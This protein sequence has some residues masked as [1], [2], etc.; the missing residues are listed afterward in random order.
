M[1][2]P[3]IRFEQYAKLGCGKIPSSDAEK[4]AVQIYTSAENNESYKINKWV[5]YESNDRTLRYKGKVY[6]ISY[7]VSVL[8]SVLCSPLLQRLEEPIYVY[9]GVGRDTLSLQDIGYKSTTLDPSI[10]VGFCGPLHAPPICTLFQ[11]ELPKGFPVYRVC[12]ENSEHDEMEIILSRGTWFLPLKG[13]FDIYAKD[14]RTWYEKSPTNIFKR[15]TEMFDRKI[16][17]IRV[18]AM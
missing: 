13:S 6:N 14:L 3:L 11:I 2:F 7:L 8:D 17:V 10:A 16:H 1:S 15:K 9:R 18:R 5:R 12:K 4:L